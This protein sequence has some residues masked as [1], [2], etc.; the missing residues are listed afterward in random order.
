MCRRLSAAVL[1]VW[2]DKA[3]DAG[4]LGFFAGGLWRQLVVRCV[5]EVRFV[6]AFLYLFIYL[7]VSMCDTL[8]QPAA[9]RPDSTAPYE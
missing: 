3:V 5:C 1:C 8:C 6:R 4:T 9:P 2:G 7:S